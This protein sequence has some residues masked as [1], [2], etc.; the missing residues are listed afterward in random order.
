MSSLTIKLGPLYSRLAESSD[1]HN[2]NVAALPSE[3]RATLRYHQARTWQAIMNSDADVIFDTALTGDGKSL[4]GQLPMLVNGWSGLFL[5]PTNELI[6][7]QKKQVEQYIRA[8]NARLLCRTMYSEAI[9]EAMQQA[10]TTSRSSLIRRYFKSS[11][12]ILSNPDLFHMFGSYNYG[13]DADKREHVYQMP[14]ILD[15]FVLDEFH[16]FGLQQIISVLNI[17]N[18]QKVAFPHDRLKY[19]FL[20]ATPTKFFKKML[21]DSGF[22]VEEIAGSYSSFPAHGYTQSPIVQPVTLY[23]KSMSEQG[24]YGWAKEHLSELIEFYQANPGTKGVFIVNSVATAKRLID[25]YKA[26][27]QEKRSIQ[28]AENTGLTNEAERKRARDKDVQLVVAT[29]TVDVGVDFHINLLIFESSGAGTF[30]QRLGRLGRHVRTDWHEYRA[31]ALLPDWIA[32]RFAAHFQDG[33]EVERRAF[34]KTIQASDDWTQIDTKTSS[35]LPPVFQPEQEYQHYAR[36]WGGIQTAHIIA[37]AESIGGFRGTD[38][39]RLLR[40]QYSIAYGCAPEKGWIDK[41]VNRYYALKNKKDRFEGILIKELTSFRG[42]S[43]LDCGIWDQTDKSFKTYDLFFLLA[44]TRFRTLKEQ[45]FKGMVEAHNQPF[46]RYSSHHLGLYVRLEQFTEEHANFY[47]HHNSSFKGKLNQVCVLDNFRIQGSRILAEQLDTRV[48]DA[49]GKVPLVCL[50]VR[51]KPQVFK[52]SHGL[53]LLFPIYQVTDG[54]DFLYSIIFGLHA[55]LAHSL[56]FWR[57]A[58][59]EDDY[60]I[61]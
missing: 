14:S 28:V 18:Y 45:Q 26:E 15:Y 37:S 11:D 36:L 48:I 16:T 40:Q 58:E 25:F 60:F 47:L 54:N 53:S 39:S 35:S 56:V 29:S 27:L 61:C 59:H 49:L 55:F 32:A 43:P 38:F 50:I 21:K 33:A 41:Q 4:A 20:S 12:S 7:D 23:I 3:Y 44:N 42:R 19:V 6:E 10:D 8:F 31:Y 5:Y 13:S 30:V 22:K 9:T 57:E 34:L 24:A 2:L 46:E 51:E 1:L 52:R 17:M